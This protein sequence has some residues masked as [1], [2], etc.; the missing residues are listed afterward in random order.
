[1]HKV[2]SLVMRRKNRVLLVADPH[3]PVPPPLYGGVERIV[4][5]LAEGLIERGWDVT[6]ACNSEST[7]KVNQYH[8]SNS[9]GWRRLRLV[10]ALKVG[11]QVLSK[12]YDLI[13]SFAHCDQTALMWPLAIPQIQSF[14]SPPSISYLE[15]RMRHLPP[16]NLY[17]TTCGRHMVPLVASLATTRA[18]HNG[19]KLGDFTFREEVA[20]DAPLVFLGRIEPI[21][22]PHLAIQ[23][24]LATGRRLIIAGNRS[25]KPEIDAYFKNEIEPAL[26]EQIS[27]VGPVDDIQK[28]RLLG[29][30][31]AFLM[32][33]LWD[34][35]FGIVI[36]EALAC[37]TPVIGF[38]RGAMPEIVIEGLTGACCLSLEEMIEAVKN[39]GSYNRKACRDDIEARFSS[40]K[41]VTDYIHLYEAV[42]S[43][44]GVSHE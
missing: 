25:E 10:N 26:S 40:Q 23:I 9:G 41:I 36:A 19:V 30:A 24:A 38:S 8:L 33:I 31:A 1:M 6:L 16:R 37:G 17:F 39:V 11:F 12:R 32:P 13:H 3:L 2:R 43:G 7:C 14:Q 28:N 15:K 18:I 4:N 34:E 22:G 21:K 35:P 5:F 20:C 42:I 29:C 44:G 27:Y